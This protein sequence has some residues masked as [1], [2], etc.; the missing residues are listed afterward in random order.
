M[1]VAIASGTLRLIQFGVP[2]AFHGGLA[3]RRTP[4]FHTLLQLTIILASAAVAAMVA[5]SR[6]VA[7]T[8]DDAAKAARALLYDSDIGAESLGLL[9]TTLLAAGGLCSGITGGAA[10]KARAIVGPLTSCM[11]PK[12]IKPS[13]IGGG[14][15]R[16]DRAS[17]S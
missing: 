12:K 10:V 5:W 16:L 14:L 11:S 13:P 4:R 6:Y 7:D 9:L 8:A 1:V 3:A 2:A 15:R 17:W